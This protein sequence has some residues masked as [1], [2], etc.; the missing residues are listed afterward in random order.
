[1]GI[2]N[3]PVCLELHVHVRLD[4]KKVSLLVP[5]LSKQTRRKAYF[6]QIYILPPKFPEH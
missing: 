6:F 4:E 2:K 3:M 5:N 1:M